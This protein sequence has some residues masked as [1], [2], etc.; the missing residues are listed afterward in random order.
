MPSARANFLTKHCNIIYQGL[1]TETYIDVNS[2]IECR[3]G[4]IDWTG[5]DVYVGVDLSMT[6]DN[7]SVSIAGMDEYGNILAESWGFIP[8]GRIDEKSQAER[9]DY[10]QM[11]EEG[12]VFACGDL[13]IDYAFV[14]D[15][16]F[17]LERKLGCNIAA[18][19]YDRYNAMSSAQK[20]SEL[21]N[22][23]EIRQHS[24]VLHPPTKLLKE[25]IE[26]H[27]FKYE[28]NRMLEINFQNARCTYDTNLNMYVNKK[29]SNGKVDM[30]VSLINAVYLLQQEILAN[31]DGFVAGVY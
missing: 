22:V 15:F 18:I 27:E 5:I 28:L 23:V 6:N 29:R 21:Y 16:V 26:N 14:E 8:D 31:G 24:S 19:G 2:V 12:H 10:R 20:W 4:P 25:K 1:G 3:T 11:C 30:V 9:I 17:D 7:T 13:T